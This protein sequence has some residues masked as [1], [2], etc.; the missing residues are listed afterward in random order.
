MIRLLRPMSVLSWLAKHLRLAG[1]VSSGSVAGTAYPARRPLTHRES[2][3]AGRSFARYRLAFP[4]PPLT[5]NSSESSLSHF[6]T[7]W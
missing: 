2:A 3:W 4:L 5:Q 7:P 1:P 6:T